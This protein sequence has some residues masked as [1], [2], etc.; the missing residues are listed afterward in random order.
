MLA[1]RLEW[2]ESDGS[3][4]SFS[5]LVIS[6]PDE[7]EFGDGGERNLDSESLRD[8]IANPNPWWRFQFAP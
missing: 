2:R 3:D 5:S 4:G 6:G 7:S 8:V 1:C